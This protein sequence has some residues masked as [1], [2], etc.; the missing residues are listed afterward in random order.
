VT[1][2]PGSGRAAPDRVAVAETVGALAR[3]CHPVPAGRGKLSACYESI[4][5]RGGTISHEWLWRWE[6]N[7]PFAERRFVGV[8]SEMPEAQALEIAGQP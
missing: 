4:E 1:R 5:L 2:R 6:P 7:D 8:V 3:F